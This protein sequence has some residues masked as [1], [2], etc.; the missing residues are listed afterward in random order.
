MKECRLIVLMSLFKQHSYTYT[1]SGTQ[2]SGKWGSWDLGNGMASFESSEILRFIKA[3]RWSW[4]A[5]HKKAMFFS[6]RTS[7]VDMKDFQWNWIISQKLG[8]PQR[9]SYKLC[10]LLFPMI[11]QRLLNEL[12]V[13]VKCNFNEIKYF[14]L[15]RM[16]LFSWLE[17]NS[18]SSY[19]VSILYYLRST[20]TIK[21]RCQVN[22]FQPM[23]F[24]QS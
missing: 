13:K 19:F 15:Q 23:C 14:S 2:D 21:T 11:M 10:V 4:Q 9:R 7:S 20:W 18:S 16:T 5:L 1:L 6:A 24:L 3:G 22:P 12:K 8:Q 17:N